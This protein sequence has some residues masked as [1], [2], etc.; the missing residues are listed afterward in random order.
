M[1][2]YDLVILGGGS[3]GLVAAE[4]AHLFRKKTA[5]VAAGKLGG[6]SLWYGCIPSKALLHSSRHGQSLAEVQAQ[7]RKAQKMIVDHHENPDYFRKKGIDVF[8]SPAEFATAHTLK[9]GDEIIAGKYILIATGSRPAVPPIDGLTET[10]FLTN[11]DVFDLK[12]L[13]KKIIVLGGGPIGCEL[14]QAFQHLGSE[15]HLIQRNKRLLPKEEPEA[16]ELILNRFKKQGI[17]VYLSSTTETVKKTPQGGAE[18]TLQHEGKTK[19]VSA[20]SVLVAI[21]RKPNIYHL[22]LDKLNIRT[23]DYGVWHNHKLQTNMRHI[24]VAGDAAGDYLFTH[25]AGI[26]AATAVRNMFLPI[27]KS[28]APKVLSWVTFTNPEIAHAGPTEEEIQKRKL[29]YTTVMINYDQID[30]AVAEGH[31]DGFI[32]MFV[33]QNGRIIG[34]QIVG[35]RAGEMIHEIILAMECD[36]HV[37]RLVGII[38]AYPT[39]SSGIQ[40]ALFSSIEKT[41]ASSVAVGRFLSKLT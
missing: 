8:L 41:A 39:Y 35:Y 7:I 22:G 32:K 17:H 38:H 25:W 34:A 13:P 31:T 30:R 9:V 37:K 15:V 23:T 28:F 20:D 3:A 40:Q 10:P 29:K 6:D 5:I 33:G 21:G 11:E 14:A 16:S 2:S 36:I 24:Y 12:T 4:T 19:T 27:K 18:I 26:Q 1:K